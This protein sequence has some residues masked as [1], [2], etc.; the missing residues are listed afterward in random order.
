MAQIEGGTDRRSVNI[1]L[2]LVPFIDLMSVCITFL[3]ITAVWTQVS[4]IQI[5]SS[6]YSRKTS[7]EVVLPKPLQNVAFRLDIRP[8]GYRVNIGLQSIIVP[9]SLGKFDTE[10]LQSRLKTIKAQYPEKEDAVISINDELQ[11]NELIV[12][13]DELL[14]A[15]FPEI[16]IMPAEVQ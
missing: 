7:D 11:Y 8:D 15:G 4:M 14:V 3:L 16:T 6:I 10:N 13:M 1:D 5:G 2:N 12:G 9:K